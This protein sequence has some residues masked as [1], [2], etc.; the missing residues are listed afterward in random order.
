M[1]I[2]ALYFLPQIIH[3]IRR[4]I[5]TGFAPAYV[6]GFL[7]LRRF[8]VPLYER[9]CPENLFRIHPDFF[10]IMGWFVLYGL[11]ILVLYG[12]HR[13]GP[14]FMIP[15][16]CISGSF[17]YNFKYKVDFNDVMDCPICLHALYLDPEEL[18]AH[19]TEINASTES[20]A[21][22]ENLIVECQVVR[23]PCKHMYHWSCFKN[24]MNVKLEC[25]VCRAKLPPLLE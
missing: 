13:K 18:D 4:G 2:Q 1:L 15:R 3:N 25:P 20:E 5:S 21:N 16:V 12:Q 7:T 9:G 23:S 14:R 10:F 11:Q 17:D 19:S 6:F 8:F 24:W 22:T